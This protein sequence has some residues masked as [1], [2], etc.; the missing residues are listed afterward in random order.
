M[1]CGNDAPVVDLDGTAD[2]P[3]G[4]IDFA[5]TFTEGT[6]AVIVDAANLTVTD[7]DNPNLDSA[8]V[9]ITNLLDAGVETLTATTTG[10]I[11][12]NYVAPALTLTGT[13]TL[14]NYQ[15]VLRTVTYNNT[16]QNPN[17]TAR[18]ITF[19]GND[20]T[21]DSALAT[22]TVT[23]QA[24]NSAPSFTKGADQTVNEDAGAQTVSGWATAISDGDGNT[25]TL[26]F[27]VTDNTNAALFSTGP[28]I[29][30]AGVLTY[31]PAAGANGTATI[32]ITLSD[33]GATG[34]ECQHQCAADVHHHGQCDQ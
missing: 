21:V 2:D 22:S 12:V 30:P 25:Q 29:S 34:T 7:V 20:G 3:G 8:T 11:T 6:P 5:V 18:T 19:V 13:D 24:I 28:A 31:T 33:D 10:S 16:S 4:D 27:N 1:T 9:T 23:I 32:T 17:T 15:Q 14:A 26:T